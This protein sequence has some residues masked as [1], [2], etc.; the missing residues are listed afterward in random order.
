[1]LFLAMIGFFTGIDLT[2]I[3]VLSHS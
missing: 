2:Y 1:L 3:Q